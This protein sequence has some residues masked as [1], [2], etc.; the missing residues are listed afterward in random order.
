MVI[1]N[2]GREGFRKI[3]L[4]ISLGWVLRLELLSVGFATISVSIS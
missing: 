3:P 1:M 2:D 4:V